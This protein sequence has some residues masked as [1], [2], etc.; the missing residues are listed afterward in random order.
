VGSGAEGDWPAWLAGEPGEQP[1]PFGR[2]KR[3]DL[4]R[5][6]QE[7]GPNG[8]PRRD[9]GPQRPPARHDKTEETKQP[10]NGGG[11]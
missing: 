9:L 11:E 3:G 10:A 8:L 4:G 2:K 5:S 1:G 7:R 6:I